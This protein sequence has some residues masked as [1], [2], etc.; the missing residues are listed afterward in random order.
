MSVLDGATLSGFTPDKLYNCFT[1]VGID[2][3]TFGLIAR[4]I[5]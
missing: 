1:T 2:P 5:C 3:A 4:L